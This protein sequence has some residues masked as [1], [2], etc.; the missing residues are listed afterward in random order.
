MRSMDGI[1][2][3][4]LFYQNKVL[5]LAGEYFNTSL[6]LRHFKKYLEDF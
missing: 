5:F 1:Q 3:G 6:V 2:N 4:F